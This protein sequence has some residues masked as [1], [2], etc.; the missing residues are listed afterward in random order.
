MLAFLLQ[1][2]DRVLR[3]V[4][5]VKRFESYRDSQGKLSSIPSRHLGI[6]VSWPV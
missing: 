2:C 3:L 1:T 5:I 4:Q 6:P